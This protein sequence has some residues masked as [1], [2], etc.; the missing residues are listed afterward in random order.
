R[1][2]RRAARATRR[3]TFSASPRAAT[4]TWRLRRG[5]MKRR[6][7]AGWAVESSFEVASRL[8]N[9]LGISLGGASRPLFH[10]PFG[11][12]LAQLRCGEAKLPENFIRVLADGGRV[13][14]NAR[15]RFREMNPRREQSDWARGRVIALDEGAALLDVAV[16]HDFADRQNRRAE[17]I[18]L[19]QA[20]P[21]LLASFSAGPDPDDLLQFRP[22]LAA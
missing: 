14:V 7:G 21:N 22:M 9:D 6:C 11:A 20:V 18:Q 1:D 16:C 17:V 10:H 4:A 19:A 3:S 12:K 5:S 8:V 13:V 2:R 15:R